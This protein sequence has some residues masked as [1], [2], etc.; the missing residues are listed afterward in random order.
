MISWQEVINS[1][2]IE[3]QWEASEACY[4]IVTS[5]QM[6]NKVHIIF[7]GQVERLRSLVGAGYCG[8]ETSEEYNLYLDNLMLPRSR[9]RM[10]RTG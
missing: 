10:L 5:E 6:E 9:W 7:K 8:G 4:K 2:E 1:L 3:W